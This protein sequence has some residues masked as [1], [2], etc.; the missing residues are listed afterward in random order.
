MTIDIRRPGRDRDGAARGLGRELC[1]GALAA[2]G[3]RVVIA[4]LGPRGG[5]DRR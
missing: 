2:R 4:D 1:A 3:A 5:D